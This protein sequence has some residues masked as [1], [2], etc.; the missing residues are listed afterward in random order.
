MGGA[1]IGVAGWRL[2]HEGF[3][4]PWSL[5]VIISGCNNRCG[6]FLNARRSPAGP[7]SLLSWSPG[8]SQGGWLI[9]GVWGLR[10]PRRPY[11]WR[12]PPPPWSAFAGGSRWRPRAPPE[13][14][15]EGRA[16]WSPRWQVQV[17]TPRQVL[18]SVCR[19]SL[20]AR[21]PSR[22]S[23]LAG[24]CGP[25]EGWKG[26]CSDRCPVHAQGQAGGRGMWEA[27][28]AAP[29]PDLWMRCLEDP[30]MGDNPGVTPSVPLAGGRGGL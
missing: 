15:A 21:S 23:S 29:C 22:D 16:G 3:Q 4:R 2:N 7:A 26:A 5:S 25:G 8:H 12:R 1:G 28:W 13:A 19:V 6:N 10:G 27:G 11:C 14:S 17:L 30:E 20:L 9:L 18:H 24:G